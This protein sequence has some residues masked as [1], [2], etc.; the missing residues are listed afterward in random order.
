[1]RNAGSMMVMVA[2]ACG[3]A[4]PADSSA[5][6]DQPAPASGDDGLPPVTSGPAML[7]QTSA[8]PGETEAPEPIYDVELPP[9]DPCE[10]SW[11]VGRLTPRVV[12]VI[13]LSGSMA[14]QTFDHDVDPRT[15]PVTRWS[16]LRTVL[17]ERLPEWDASH[18]IG[19][20]PFP[21]T[22]A[23]PPPDASAC[24]LGNVAVVPAFANANDVLDTLPLADDT[25]LAG[26]TPLR[27]AILQARALLSSNGGEPN[28]AIVIITDGAP[29][30][31]PGLEPPASFDELDYDAQRVLLDLNQ[32]G[33][34]T[35]IIALDVPDL[36]LPAGNGEPAGNPMSALQS[37]AL[38]GDFR[39]ANDVFDLHVAL[40]ELRLEIESTRVPLPSR[41]TD[42]QR[43]DVEIDGTIY[44]SVNSCGDDGY[45]R[46]DGPQGDALQMCGAA[47]TGL[48]RTGQATI[49]PYCFPR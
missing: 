30:C 28:K 16:G 48:Q 42:I 33:I 40:S 36:R 26:A 9:V 29:N 5:T 20:Q 44:F 3:P 43:Y 25:A 4:V 21:S 38:F 17:E 11:T 41:I 47:L 39:V 37:L 32:D 2:L 13:D 45:M 15:P 19:L 6:S 23:P 46:I 22:T 27:G 10:M 49:R 18:H 24:A 31:T 34:D 35:T 7:P 1:M 8:W 14:T 12:F